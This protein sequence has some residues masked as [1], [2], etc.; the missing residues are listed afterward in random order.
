MEDY[1]SESEDEISHTPRKSN[2]ILNKKSFPK[3]GVNMDQLMVE[4]EQEMMIKKGFISNKFEDQSTA[5]TH[6]NNYFNN[7]EENISSFDNEDLIP[8]DKR[9]IWEI[10]AQIARNLFEIGNFN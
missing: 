7:K 4:K 9:K 1:L 3:K 8:S 5:L 10:K 6:S 2:F